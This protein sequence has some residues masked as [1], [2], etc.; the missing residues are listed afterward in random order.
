MSSVTG[1]TRSLASNGG[2]CCECREDP[3]LVKGQGF[4]YKIDMMLTST[5]KTM[6]PPKN[7][8]KLLFLERYCTDYSILVFSLATFV[9]ICNSGCPALFRGNFN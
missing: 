5:H 8:I 6:T 1:G 2:G 7:Q 4:I 3:L 9:F